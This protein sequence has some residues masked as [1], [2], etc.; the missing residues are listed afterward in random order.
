MLG[1]FC[2]ELEDIQKEI[3]KLQRKNSRSTRAMNNQNF[4]PNSYVKGK[5]KFGKI[6]KGK[7]VWKNSK[8]YQKNSIEIQELYRIQA[9]KRK[10]L[11]NILANEALSMGKYV[12][13]ENNNYKAWQK[14]WFGKTIGFRAPS[15]FVSTLTRKAESA[16]GKVDLIDT[17]TSKLSQYCH[18]CDGYHKK[19]LS[20]RT[21][22]C[23][24]ITK[25][26]DLYSALLIKH[27]DLEAR[28]VN[29]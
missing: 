6:K 14:G 23:G 26:R 22:T 11:H 15:A 19:T 13:I 25:Q 21:H 18:V 24:E 10:T 28:K 1:P 7:N 2:A 4:E 3:G 9:D 8:N 12:K 16:G 29:T 17:W 27:Y 5:K 20:E